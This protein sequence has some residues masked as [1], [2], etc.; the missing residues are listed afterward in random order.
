MILFL[1]SLE[2]TTHQ[3]CSWSQRHSHKPMDMTEMNVIDWNNAQLC[4]MCKSAFTTEP[5][6]KCRDHDHRTGEYRGAA[7]ADCNLRRQ[8]N[9][10]KL[11]VVMHNFKG[12]DVHHIVREGLQAMKHWNTSVIPLTFEKYLSLQARFPHEHSTC[13]LVFIDSFQF[14]T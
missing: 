14:L 3:T 10:R 12:Y 4:Y 7:C 11:T 5:S 13:S 6:N 1:K 9:R 8:M 2:A